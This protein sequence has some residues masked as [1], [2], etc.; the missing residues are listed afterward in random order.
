MK[1]YEIWVKR[2]ASTNWIHFT[3][4]PAQDIGKILQ[5]LLPQGNYGVKT[6]EH[7]VSKL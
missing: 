5:E 7:F 6:Y 2:S 4:I 3:T 1:K